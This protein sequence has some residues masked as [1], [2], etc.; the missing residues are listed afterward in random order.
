MTGEALYY[1]AVVLYFPLNRGDRSAQLL[2]FLYRA[3]KDYR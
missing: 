2:Y 3:M 1:I